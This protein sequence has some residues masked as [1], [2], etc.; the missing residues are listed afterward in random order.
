MFQ[1]HPALFDRFTHYASDGMKERFRK[2]WT[3]LPG[4]E[5][6]TTWPLVIGPGFCGGTHPGADNVFLEVM[7]GTNNF[8]YDSDCLYANPSRK[9]FAISDP[10]GITD[11]SRRLFANLDRRL[12]KSCASDLEAILND[13]NREVGPDD[14][15]TLSLLAFPPATS[16]SGVRTALAFVAGDSSVFHGNLSRRG[17][18][19]IEGIPDFVGTPHTYL[20]PIAIELTEGDFFIIV[21]DGILSIRGNDRERALAGILRECVDGDPQDFAFRAIR[22]SNQCLEERIYDRRLTRFGGSDN[23][24]ALLVYPEELTDAASQESFILGGCI[25]RRPG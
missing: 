8:I 13:L 14:G 23:V 9:V 25:T 4:Y 19:P 20:E 1:Q 22:D 5:T 7:L 10:P 11:S 15:A 24:S 6:T 16:Q 21:S 12:K 18:T 2:A 17:M 3:T